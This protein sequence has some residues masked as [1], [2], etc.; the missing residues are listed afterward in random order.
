MTLGSPDNQMVPLSPWNVLSSA[1]LILATRRS[2][3]K[4]LGNSDPASP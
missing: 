1:T 2:R 4:L 3:L